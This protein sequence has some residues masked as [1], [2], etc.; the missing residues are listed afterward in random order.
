MNTLK[1]IY[2]Q[3]IFAFFIVAAVDAHAAMVNYT[4]DNVIL[5]DGQQITGTFDWTYSVDDFEGGSGAFT[6]LEIPYTS[7]SFADGNL[8]L[9]IQPDSIEIS[10]NGNFHDVGLDITLKLSPS[11]TPTQSASMD[12]GLSFFE[13]CG[14]GF[15]DQPFQSGSIV[16]STVLAGDF[17]TDGDVDGSDFLK[18]QKGDVS[19][20][21][22]SS[23]LAAWEANYGSVAPPLVASVPEPSA[24]L[25]GVMASLLGISC[26]RR[27]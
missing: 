27:A 13:C 1:K 17:D 25:L 23:D 20:P 5:A 10:G 12:L 24:V 9:D 18:W 8:N 14:N 19:S 22:S 3:M 26:R 6:A 15:K 2:Y 11:F 16:P 4:L 21:P 7:Y